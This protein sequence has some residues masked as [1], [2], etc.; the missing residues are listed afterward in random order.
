ME[1]KLMPLQFCII[2]GVFCTYTS[3]R[4]VAI[5]IKNFPCVER[6]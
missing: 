5:L 3:C 1:W 2:C 4:D 6:L